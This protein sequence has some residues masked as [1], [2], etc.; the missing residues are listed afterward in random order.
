MGIT[1]NVAKNN[2][3]LTIDVSKIIAALPSLHDA[4]VVEDI[5][6]ALV[7]KTSAAIASGVVGVTFA[8]TIV[9]NAYAPYGLHIF[10]RPKPI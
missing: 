5:S 2:I 6:P 10:F 9:S 1:Y 4:N 7:K 3:D 8:A